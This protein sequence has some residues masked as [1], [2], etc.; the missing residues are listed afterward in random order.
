M[1]WKQACKRS[2]HHIAVRTF[3]YDGCKKGT[4]FCLP[5]GTVVSVLPHR[6]QTLL[7]VGDYV[8]R[9]IRVSS[10]RWQP[11]CLPGEQV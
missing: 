3:R 5:G 8:G 1:T 11:L 6:R 10:N 4:Y 9:A 2:R 7:F